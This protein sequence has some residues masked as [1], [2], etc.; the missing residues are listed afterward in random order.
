MTPGE[1]QP[2]GEERRG[3]RSFDEGG[4][5][6]H[7]EFVPVRLVFLT[8]RFPRGVHRCAFGQPVEAEVDDRRGVEGEHLAEDQ[9]ADDGDAEGAAQLGAHARAEGQGQG[10]RAGPP[11]WS[12]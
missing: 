10:A 1:G 12:S 3:D 8:C 6:I 11:W 4:G 9:A 7:G 5:D 2:D